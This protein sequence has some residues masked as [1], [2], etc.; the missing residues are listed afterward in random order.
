M[1]TLKNYHQAEL[2]DLDV[3][4][5]AMLLERVIPGDYVDF[6]SDKQLLITMFRDMQANRLPI[7][8]I[9]T[10]PSEILGIVPLTEAEYETAKNCG[11][12]T[13]LIAYLLSCARKV[14][15]DYFFEDEIF[16]L[17][18]DAYYKNALHSEKGVSVID[19]VGYQDA[20]IFE[21]M[22]MLTYELVMHAS[23]NEYVRKYHELVSFFSGI[24]DTGRF[25]A[26]TFV[27]LVKQL[28][29]SIYEANDG[30]VRAD[31]YLHVIQALFLDD[32]ER[33]SLNL[34]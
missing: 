26:A 33:L 16:L 4:K 23:A 1:K 34:K 31:R 17:H 27:F 15:A 25:N 22:P 24:T 5:R 7:S 6:E 10:I 18:G 3:D 28:I 21:F 32:S 13:E 8:A 19:P 30:F 29:P 9:K 12:H 2:L 11:Y 14:Y 20:F